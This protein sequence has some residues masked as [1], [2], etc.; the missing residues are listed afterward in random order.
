MPGCQ[1]LQMTAYPGLAQDVL[2]LYPYG[3]SVRQRVKEDV[4]FCL[5]VSRRR[6]T[7]T[8]TDEFYET[9][10]PLDGNKK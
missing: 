5:F 7:R 9:C 3:N 8:V 2:Q 1:K 6:P 10:R 4:M